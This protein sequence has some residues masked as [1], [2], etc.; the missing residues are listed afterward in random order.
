M[1]DDFAT[2]LTRKN[3]L[4]IYFI[5]GKARSGKSTLM[6]FIAGHP[7][8]KEAVK[9]R[10]STGEYMILKFFFWNVRTPLQKSHIRLLRSLLHT[11]LHRFPELIPATFPAFYSEWKV[12]EGEEEPAYISVKSAFE[13][14]VQKS[15]GFLKLCIFIDSINEFEGD[16]RDIS[17]YL[18]NLSSPNI[19]LVISSQPINACINAFQGCP[20][21]RLQDLTRNNI[22][23]FI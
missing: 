21:L 14:L 18:Q 16:K 5:Q 23:I 11:I 10:A 2:Y 13:L 17:R 3:D 19:K 15:A 8:V 20:T 4:S 22:Q 6:K 12:K 9:F 7:K 1:W